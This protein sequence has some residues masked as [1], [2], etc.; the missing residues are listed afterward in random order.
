[1]RPISDWIVINSTYDI[2]DSCNISV[3]V[4][5]TFSFFFLFLLMCCKFQC[6]LLVIAKRVKI[7]KLTLKMKIKNGT[8]DGANVLLVF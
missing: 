6:F 8:S 7:Q 1:M 5:F 2:Y 4:R 3:S